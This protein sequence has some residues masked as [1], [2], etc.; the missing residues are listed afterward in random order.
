M[1]QWIDNATIGHFFNLLLAGVA[2]G[3]F[4]VLIYDL[5]VTRA[6]GAVGLTPTGQI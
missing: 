5:A 2:A 4:A 6:E 1:D 3:F